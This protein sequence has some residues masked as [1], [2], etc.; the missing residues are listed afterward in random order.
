MIVVPHTPVQARVLRLYIAAHNSVKPDIW[1]AR[2]VT[3]TADQPLTPVLVA[4]WDSGIDTGL[5]PGQFFDDPHP[6]AS[7][8]HGLAF[9]DSGAPSTAWLYPLTPEQQARYPE[10]R[11]DFKG[12]LDIEEGHDSPEAVAPGEEAEDE[13]AGAASPARRDPQGHWV[14]HARDPLRGDRGAGQSGRAPRRRPLRRRPPRPPLPAH[15]GMGQAHGC[16]FPP[17]VGLLQD[18]E[19]AR[20]QHELG[21]RPPG[22]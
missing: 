18:A 14:L 3:L 17:D 4:I 19:R 12:R 21:R 22:V 16:G 6:T 1:A 13:L 10:I 20:R 7:G 15:P 9:D 11:D 2:E 5:F 8:V